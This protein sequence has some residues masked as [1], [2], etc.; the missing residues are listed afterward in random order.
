MAETQSGSFFTI[1]CYGGPLRVAKTGTCKI[2]WTG[3]YFVMTC[4]PLTP[5]PP[6]TIKLATQESDC[7]RSSLAG[8]TIV[9]RLYGLSLW[10]G[11]L[12]LEQQSS[13]ILALCWAECSGY[14][15]L[16]IVAVVS[17][18]ILKMEEEGPTSQRLHYCIWILCAGQG[19]K[20][21]L[22]EEQNDK[23]RLRCTFWL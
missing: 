19:F 3:D 20:F 2:R 12:E 5:Q 16:G 10:I 23:G 8:R 6:V 1:R 22:V 11:N 14:V 15:D 4:L 7:Q 9:H 18:S 13:G 21:Y 17:G